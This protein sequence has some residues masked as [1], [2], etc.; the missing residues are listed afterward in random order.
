VDVEWR[1][2]GDVTVILS[3]AKDLVVATVGVEEFLR[4]LRGSE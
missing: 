4:R 1:D 2:D 3:E